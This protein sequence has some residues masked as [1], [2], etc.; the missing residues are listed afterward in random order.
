MGIINKPSENRR[1]II[2]LICSIMVLATNV[3]INFFLSPYI[4]KHIGVEANGFILLANNLITY[5]ELAVAALNSMAARYIAIAYVKRDYKKANMYYNSVFWGNLIIVGALLVPAAVFLLKINSFINIPPHLVASVR[6]LFAFIIFNFFLT[7]GMPNY[8]CG[9]YVS[10]R[11]DRSYIPKMLT[12]VL[13]CL[14]LLLLFSILAPKVWYV[15]LAATIVAVVMLVCNGYNTHKLT[16]HLRVKL[17]RPFICSMNAIHELVGSGIWNTI[18]NLGIL[19]LN[20]LDL[21]MCN[22]LL[23]PTEMG[24]LSISKIMPTYMQQLSGSIRDSFSPE[25]TIDYARGNKGRLMSNIS[26][27]IKITSVIMTIPVAIFIVFGYDFFRLW[28]PTQDASLLS[29]LAVISI[30]GYAL[31]SGVQILYNVFQVTNRVKQNAIAVLISGVVSILIMFFFMRF[32]KY[33]IYAA[34]GASVLCNFI[35]NMVFTLPATARY[36]GLKWKTFFGS[37]GKCLLVSATLVAVNIVVRVFITP[38][39]WGGLIVAVAITAVLDLAL[40]LFLILTKTDRKF[41]SNKIRSK[42]IKNK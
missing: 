1:T 19:L 10:N 30:L 38:T 6:A 41:I 9:T 17:R 27:A 3:V 12:S 32:T 4:I 22:W 26:R 14:L 29:V 34:A 40:N 8:D 2:N 33:G 18:S 13:R 20:G 28:L 39:S 36:L 42:L 24:I 16:P 11:L 25:L 23:G 15:G 5:A 35:R 21:I 7:T 31:T 37:V